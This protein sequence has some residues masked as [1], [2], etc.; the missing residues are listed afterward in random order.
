MNFKKLYENWKRQKIIRLL[1]TANPLTIEQYGANLLLPAFRRAAKK[2]PAYTERLKQKG[3]NP[4][5][6]K[7]LEDFKNRVPIFGKK[8]FFVNTAIDKLCINGDLSS[9]KLTLSSSGY[10]GTYSF[11]IN[12]EYNQK[13]IAFSIDTALEYVFKISKKKTFLVNCLPMG[14]KVPT[15]LQISETSVRADM[16]L[17]MIKKFSPHFEQVLIVSDP[18]FLKKLVEEGIEEGVNWKKM[19]VNL[20]LGEDW[21]SESFRMYLADLL[22]HDFNYPEKGIIGATLGIAE[23][24]LNLFHETIDTIRIR[25]AAQNDPKLRQKLF[26]PDVKISPIIFHYYPHRM[27]LEAG[28]NNE[29]IFSMLS[30]HFLIPLIRYNSQDQGRIFSYNT[31]KAL[32]KDAGYAQL[33]P[34]LK[35]PLV[36]VSGRKDRCLA[37]AGK[38]VSPEEI[39]EGLYSDFEVSSLTTGYFMLTNKENKGKLEIQLKKGICQTQ[40][41]K[42]KF[43]KAALKF[44]DV[45]LEVILYPY[46]DFPYGM[47]VDYERKFKNI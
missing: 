4:R 29:L 41:I 38:N 10:S 16:A 5:A 27:Y 1:T 21:F 14:V 28:D 43:E 46:Q 32:L 12:T 17:A 19:N 40:A 26:G 36:A 42:T 6:I 15:T 45:Y 9:M 35:L 11:G 22:G 39:K 8:D 20:I 30:S 31:I 33:I 2:M 7:T 24:D 13:N 3:I 23:L 47:E 25:Q 37:L 44:T 18:H 34:E